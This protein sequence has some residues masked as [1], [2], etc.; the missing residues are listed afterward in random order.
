[1]G[2]GHRLSV[3]VLGVP[4]GHGLSL[5]NANAAEASGGGSFLAPSAAAP[6]PV[7]CLAASVVLC[8]ASRSARAPDRAARFLCSFRLSAFCGH[9]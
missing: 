1:M 9:I 3:V 6:R 4:V 5:S 8:Q 2:A 7:M